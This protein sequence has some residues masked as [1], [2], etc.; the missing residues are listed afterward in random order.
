[1]V[2]PRADLEIAM[3]DVVRSDL[4]QLQRAGVGRMSRDRDRFQRVNGAVSLNRNA[5]DTMMHMDVSL[6]MSGRS[7]Y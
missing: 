2:Q 1:M 6:D 3:M 4:G 5:D 7:Q